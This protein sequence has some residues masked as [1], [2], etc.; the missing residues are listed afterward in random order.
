[1]IVN[2]VNRIMRRL[3]AA[4]GYLELGLPAHAQTELEAVE[5]PGPF[6]GPYMLMMGECLRAQERYEEAIAPLRHAARALPMP[7]GRQAWESLAECLTRSGRQASADVTTQMLEH[8][9]KRHAAPSEPGLSARTD[10]GSTVHVQ[11][12]NL[13]TVHVKFDLENGLTINLSPVQE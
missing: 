12:P 1:M 13:G 6:E 3:R 7:V 8:L 5:H 4:E 11:I 9:E 10:D 2:P